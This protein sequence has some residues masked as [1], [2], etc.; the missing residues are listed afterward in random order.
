VQVS[1]KSDYAVRAMMEL[2]AQ[3]GGPVKGEYLAGAQQIP[4]K[5]L[6]AI[7]AQLRQA[8]LLQSRR[9]AEGGYWLAR[10]AAEITIADIIRAADGPLARVRGQRPEAVSYEGAARRLT[11]VWVAVRASLR[12]VLEAVTLQDLLDGRLSP[13]VQD[14]MADPAARTTR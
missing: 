3:G 10:P 1:A 7:L 12:A 13:A 4:P 14:L 6:E 8:G 5:F 11:E 2:A 9:G